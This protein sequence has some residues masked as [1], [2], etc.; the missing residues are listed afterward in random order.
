MPADPLIEIGREIMNR[1][2]P[3]GGSVGYLNP[4]YSDFCAWHNKG[5]ALREYARKNMLTK[6]IAQQ[7]RKTQHDYA[8]IIA[9]AKIA[10]HSSDTTTIAKAEELLD[11]M[12]PF[13]G[14]AKKDRPTRIGEL[15]VI[16]ELFNGNLSSNITAIGATAKLAILSN[17]I[18]VL[19]ALIAERGHD[20]SLKP[21]YT[22]QDVKNGEQ[23]AFIDLRIIIDGILS[24]VNYPDPSAKLQ[25]TGV[26]ADLN[27]RIDYY[28]QLFDPKRPG[29]NLNVPQ[30]TIEIL[31]PLPLTIPYGVEGQIMVKVRF[32]TGDPDLGVIELR[33]GYDYIK[34][35]EDNTAPNPSAK[36]II[37]GIKKYRGEKDVTFEI[38]V[39]H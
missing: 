34:R 21:D 27:P 13:K 9:M 32:S 23:K 30:T 29:I 24:A 25:I 39:I 20:D 12:K 10:E 16:L 26:V 28:S 1:V 33:E 19:E 17:D 14:L 22:F 11:A 4:A 38:Q 3:I 6:Q 31:T 5:V 8:D 18:S 35:Y 7:D 36:L 37:H 15:A 2:S